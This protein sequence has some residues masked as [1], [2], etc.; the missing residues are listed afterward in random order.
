MAVYVALLRAINVG[1]AGKLAMK[2]L[3]ALCEDA[4]FEDVST[5]IQTGNVV[6]R[7]KQAKAKVQQLLE[8]AVAKK[9]GKPVGVFLRSPKEL[10]TL[11][12]ESPFAKAKPNHVYVMFLDRAPTTKS[13]SDIDAPGGEQIEPLGKHLIVHYPNGMGRSKLKL[14][15]AKTGTARNMNTVSKLAEMASELNG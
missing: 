10:A 8:K 2:D 9:L 12:E 11:L 13:L 4:G 5:Y 7:C 14:E 6:F 1:G 3:R 15:A